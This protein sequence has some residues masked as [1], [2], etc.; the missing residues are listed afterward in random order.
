MPIQTLAMTEKLLDLV[1]ACQNTG[2]KV[3]FEALRQ[4]ITE[5]TK[6][7]FALTGEVA[8]KA[9]YAAN[10]Y[11]MNEA[12]ARQIASLQVEAARKGNT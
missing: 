10:M 3:D 6:Q 9:E 8:N 12:Q 7:I 2:S 5:Q 4:A 11:R 1:D